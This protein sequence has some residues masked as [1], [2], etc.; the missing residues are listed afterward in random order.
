MFDYKIGKVSSKEIKK[1]F[2]T[3]ATLLVV[4]GVGSQRQL[5]I[6]CYP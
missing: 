3:L 5:F 1:D 4:S 2:L 6:A